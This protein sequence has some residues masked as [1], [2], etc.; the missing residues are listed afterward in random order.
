MQQCNRELI[1]ELRYSEAEIRADI[2]ELRNELESL[3]K[4]EQTE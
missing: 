4:I 1:K 3:R 2:W